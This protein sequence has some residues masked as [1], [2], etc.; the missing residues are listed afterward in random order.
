MHVGVLLDMT[1]SCKGTCLIMHGARYRPHG[2]RPPMSDDPQGPWRWCTRCSA[3]L[4]WA[5]R[6]CPCCTT[7]LRQRRR[8]N[9]LPDTR[10][11]TDK[12]KALA[13]PP[14]EVRTQ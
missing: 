6:H 12:A 7:M 10:G 2:G 11:G 4:A 8:R 14:L 1:T 3:W 5:G 13:V 9:N